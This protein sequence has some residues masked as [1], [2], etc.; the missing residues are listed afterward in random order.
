MARF[1]GNDE[2]QKEFIKVFN[3]ISSKHD[4]WNVWN[5]FL[6]VFAAC[7]Q[8]P[9]YGKEAALRVKTI[10]ERYSEDYKK[11]D[12]LSSIVTDALEYRFQDFL[13]EVYMGL[14]FGNKWKG[15]FF[16]PYE[17]CLMMARMTSCDVKGLENERYIEINDPCIG[18]GAMLI[19]T[20]DRLQEQGFDFQNKVL[21]TAQDIDYK[22]CN[23]AYIQLSLLGAAGQV[24]WGDCLQVECRK[25]W[26]TPVYFLNH[27]PEKL[28]SYK[29]LDSMKALMNTPELQPKTPV[30][31]IPKIEYQRTETGQLLMN[32]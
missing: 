18:G 7:L 10:A 11:M 28:R 21:F 24:I 17:I 15:Q 32:F 20:C 26:F 27:W 29:L 25:A 16:T 6:D 23:M 2:Y 1:R 22:C 30:I 3:S 13:G 4:R 31:D 14:E 19:A 5:D 9:F 12:K 8:M